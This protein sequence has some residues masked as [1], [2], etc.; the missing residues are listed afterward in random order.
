MNDV[1]N[2][3][4]AIKFELP[5]VV[6]TALQPLAKNIGETL[7]YI[8]LGIFTPVNA[9]GI[10]KQIQSNLNFISKLIIIDKCFLN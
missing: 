6:N 5:Q 3:P 1:N 10:K 7:G 9:W 2:E 4:I 8:W